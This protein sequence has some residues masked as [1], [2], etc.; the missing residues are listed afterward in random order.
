MVIAVMVIILQTNRSQIK[1]IT[2]INPLGCGVLCS[3][4][5]YLMAGTGACSTIHGEGGGLTRQHAHIWSR[6][7]QNKYS[8][9]GISHIQGRHWTSS[10]IL[11]G[12]RVLWAMAIS[13]LWP[14]GLNDGVSH[15]KIHRLILQQNGGTYRTNIA[16]P[17]SGEGTCLDWHAHVDTQQNQI[18]IMMD[19]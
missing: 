4:A 2:T 9:D 19:V 15:N 12:E 6:R 13:L 1:I 5:Y 10:L 17:M 7:C 11:D 14:C 18:A 3:A 16:M 8:G